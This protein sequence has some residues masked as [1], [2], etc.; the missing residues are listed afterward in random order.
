MMQRRQKFLGLTALALAIANLMAMPH[1]LAA[2]NELRGGGGIK[3]LLG[4]VA[5]LSTL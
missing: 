4:V 2:L 5:L 1:T 3:C